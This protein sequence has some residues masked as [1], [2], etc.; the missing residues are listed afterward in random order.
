MPKE[1][2]QVQVKE[3]PSAMT[4][5]I[6]ALSKVVKILSKFELEQQK[7]IIQYVSNAVNESISEDQEDDDDQI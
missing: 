2:E 7:R 5:E 4:L 3:T 6:S 1:K